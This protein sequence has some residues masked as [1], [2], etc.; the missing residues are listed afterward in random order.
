MPRLSVIIPTFNEQDNVGQVY[1]AVAKALEGL[2]WEIIFVDDASRD[3]TTAE[4]VTLSQEDRRVRLIRRIGRR[5]LSSA[6]IEGML[7]C[8]SEFVAVMDADLQ[9]DEKLLP[10]ML[11][12]LAQDPSLDLVVGS[13][14]C[15]RAS[16][17][18]LPSHRVKISEWATRFSQLF[19]RTS[20]TDP[21][22]GFFMLRF[23]KLEEIA[24]QL[25]GIGFK[26]LLDILMSSR[27][28]FKVEELPY[29]MRSRHQGES[30]LDAKV[31]Y[32]Y[33]LLIADKTIGIYF[34]IRLLMFLMVGATGVLVQLLFVWLLHIVLATEFVTATVVAT[35]VAMT[36]NF[37]LNNWFTHYD[38]R[39]TGAALIKGYL[40]FVL[41]CSIGATINV[42]VADLSF[43]TL[44]IWWIASPLGAVFGSIWNYTMSNILTWRAQQA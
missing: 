37:I 9:H 24:P 38:R 7:A 32:D 35:G 19:A 18:S 44:G 14:Y 29:Q 40:S 16:T 5:G 11:D 13:R 41:A 30:K 8:T 36:S 22:S 43:E 34:P 25:S 23:S 12:R 17:G 27:S 1:S 4:V 33:F 39:L 10:K 15:E 3:A 2:D 6:C 21:M 31:A 26:V 42:F 20:I 28:G